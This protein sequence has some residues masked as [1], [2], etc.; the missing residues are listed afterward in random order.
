MSPLAADSAA[1]L[2]LGGQKPQKKSF[3]SSQHCS[4]KPATETASTSECG[5]PPISGKYAPQLRHRSLSTPAGS[6]LKRPGPSPCQ[7]ATHQLRPFFYL[8]L[9]ESRGAHPDQNLPGPT[10]NHS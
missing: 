2:L 7:I 5:P 6:Q 8:N 3:F 10:N 4:P 9:S 1:M